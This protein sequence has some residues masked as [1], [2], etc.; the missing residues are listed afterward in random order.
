MFELAFWVDL[1]H[2]QVDHVIVPDVTDAELPVGF[3]VL[4]DC[5]PRAAVEEL[6]ALFEFLHR[7]TRGV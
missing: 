6:C 5:S 1:N 3:N 4:R 2:K 7:E